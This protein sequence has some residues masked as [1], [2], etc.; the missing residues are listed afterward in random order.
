MNMQILKYSIKIYINLHL[1]N[2]QIKK[3]YIYSLYYYKP[4]SE[5]LLS[6]NFLSINKLND[7]DHFIG[8]VKYTKT[9]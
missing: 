9:N 5:N 3:I 6:P 8:G 1:S 4:E 7:S 2:K